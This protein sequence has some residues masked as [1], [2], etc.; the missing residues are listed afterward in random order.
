MFPML[1]V[2]SA[3]TILN[4]IIV[5]TPK[6]VRLNQEKSAIEEVREI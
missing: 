1:R 5:Y 4:T 2:C 6:F 3:I